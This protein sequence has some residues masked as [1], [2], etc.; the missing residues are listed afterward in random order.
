[1]NRSTPTTENL[2][3]NFNGF[4]INKSL[5][6]VEEVKAHGRH[7]IHNKLKTWITE[8]TIMVR[9]MNRIAY[10]A[11]NRINFILL[12]NFLDAL[13]I[14]I[15]DRRFLFGGVPDIKMPDEF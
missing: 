2:L 13:P 14:D 1:H 6:V 9:V 3:E 5:C 4:V 15:D 7:D 8:D 12:T 11:P 10:E